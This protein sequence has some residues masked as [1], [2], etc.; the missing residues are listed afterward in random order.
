MKKKIIKKIKK[1]I[2][3]LFNYKY[4][5]KK[6]YIYISKTLKNIINFIILGNYNYYKEKIILY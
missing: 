4:S 6:L 1:I 5:F 3:I 2:G